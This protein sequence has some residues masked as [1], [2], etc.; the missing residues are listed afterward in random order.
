M[1]CE[2]CKIREAN[3]QVVEVV[4]G[5]KSEHFL[6]AQCASEMDLSV[7]APGMGKEMPLAKLLSSLLSQTMQSEKKDECANVVCPTCGMTYEQF[8]KESKFG[9]ADC[10][11]VFDLLIGDNI[12]QL[13]GSGE[14]HGKRPKYISGDIP[15]KVKEDIEE[16]MKENVPESEYLDRLIE[17]RKELR[18]AVAEEDFEKAAKLRDEIKETEEKAADSAL[19]GGGQ[20]ED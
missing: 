7:T 5:V 16:S 19:K 12:R 1:L 8:I 11:K 2:K 4:G 3:I 10:Y 14:H 20:D 9:C 6:C 18:Q 17:L 13:Q 15:Q